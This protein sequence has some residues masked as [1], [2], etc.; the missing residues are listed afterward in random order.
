MAI[1]TIIMDYIKLV[2]YGNTHI[3]CKKHKIN[4]P[5][6]DNGDNQTNHYEI[7]SNAYCK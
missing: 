1:I 4:F 6:Y 2:L 5:Y 3:I 7:K